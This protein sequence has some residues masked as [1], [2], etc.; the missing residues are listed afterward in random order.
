MRTNFLFTCMFSRFLTDTRQKYVFVIIIWNHFLINHVSSIFYMKIGDFF[1]GRMVSYDNVKCEQSLLSHIAHFI[2]IECIFPDRKSLS[3]MQKTPH[4][5]VRH[6]HVLSL[7]L[8][9]IG[10]G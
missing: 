5:T 9:F 4:C 6:Y 7:Q 1:G 3:A 2:Y 8:S 10:S